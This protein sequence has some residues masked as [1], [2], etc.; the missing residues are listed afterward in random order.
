ML[1][2]DGYQLQYSVH[3]NNFTMILLTFAV[4]C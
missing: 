3:L 1:I 2:M 4:Y